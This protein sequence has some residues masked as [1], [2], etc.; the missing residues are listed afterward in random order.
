MEGGRSWPG[1]LSDLLHESIEDDD[2][3]A[4]R[5]AV[6]SKRRRPQPS[7]RPRLVF[8][9]ALSTGIL[10][11][12]AAAFLMRPGTRT[13]ENAPILFLDS[14]AL[15][16][17]NVGEEAESPRHIRLSDGSNLD[18]SP[19]TS[20]TPLR[21][22]ERSL[23]LNLERG[24]VT[25]DVEPATGR[26][27]RVDAGLA[28]VEVVG[29]VFTVSR[30]PEQVRVSVARGQV[31][32]TGERV[33]NGEQLLSM[34]DAIEVRPRQSETKVA[35]SPQYESR[36]DPSAPQSSRENDPPERP[37]QTGSESWR[38]AA[39]RGDWTEAYAA[40]GS[41]RLRE[42]TQNSE[43][44]EELLILAD[45]ARRSGHPA[46]AVGPLQ[47]ALREHPYDRRGPVIAFTLGR[48]EADQLGHPR[49]AAIAFRRCL[50]LGPPEALREDS[51]ARL[52]EAHARAGQYDEAR[53]AAEEYLRRYPDGDRASALRR[54]IEPR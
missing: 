27:W 3:E 35:E 49:R 52:A 28:T 14:T 24:R 17:M 53:Y 51:M 44:V 40:L 42:L 47:R 18:L 26:T 41:T 30:S 32:V 31:R 50:E 39:G 2:V 13:R 25:F 12:V 11:V 7:Q 43:S 36:E 19:G 23:S 1:P 38:G 37:E 54:W 16:E 48:V 34:G 22:D 10:V 8:A 4:L 46:E 20:L 5:A 33:P 9:I 6:A 29:T 45:V 21:N 15:T